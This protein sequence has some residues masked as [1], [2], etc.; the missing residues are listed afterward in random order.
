MLK[1]QLF[2]DIPLFRQTADQCSSPSANRSEAEASCYNGE[3]FTVYAIYNKKHKKIYIGQS[4]DYM[5]RIKEH[6]D[7]TNTKHRFT[8]KFDGEWKL[9]YKEEFISRIEALKREKQLKSY[10]GRQFIKNKIINIPL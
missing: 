4:E 10:Q 2:V 7:P 9:I 5:R 6:N 3:V 8:K 1:F